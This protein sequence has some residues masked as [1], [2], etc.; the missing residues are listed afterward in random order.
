MDS[1]CGPLL[2]SDSAPT[3][4]LHGFHAW[5]WTFHCPSSTLTR[6]VAWSPQYLAQVHEDPGPLPTAML[7]KA[8][9]ELGQTDKALQAKNALAL[10]PLRHPANEMQLLSKHVKTPPIGFA[11]RRPHQ[12]LQKSKTELCFNQ[13]RM[14][15]LQI[16]QAQYWSP[17]IENGPPSGKGEDR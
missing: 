10:Q 9:E 15:A 1:P 7:R 12:F 17:V 11:K 14:S 16:D 4:V 13:M 2:E 3:P 6:S 5:M 8:V